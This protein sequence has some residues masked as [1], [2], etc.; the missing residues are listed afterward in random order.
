MTPRLFALQCL[1][2]SVWGSMGMRRTLDV[3]DAL[4]FL[5]DDFCQHRFCEHLSQLHVLLISKRVEILRFAII[6]QFSGSAP[7]T[8][9]NFTGTPEAVLAGGP[10]SLKIVISSSTK[11]G[12]LI[13]EVIASGVVVAVTASPW[14]VGPSSPGRS[15]LMGF[16]ETRF[17]SSKGRSLNCIGSPDR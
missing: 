11:P 17:A 1:L 16:P 14:A 3:G 7:A 13:E 4:G 8:P 5:R 12:C 6:V 15:D 2:V 9:S 10:S